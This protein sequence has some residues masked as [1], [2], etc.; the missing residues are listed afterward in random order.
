MSNHNSRT[1]NYNVFDFPPGGREILTCMAFIDAQPRTKK[2]HRI[3][4]LMK[5]IIRSWSGCYSIQSTHIHLAAQRMQAVGIKYKN[6]RVNIDQSQWLLPDR[7]CLHIRGVDIDA[8]SLDELERYAN[9]L[10]GGVQ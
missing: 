3:T 8:T 7:H 2:K 5:D 9:R 6:G 10:N 4:G 1:T